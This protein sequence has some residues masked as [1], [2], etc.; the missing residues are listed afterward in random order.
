MRGIVRWDF[1]NIPQWRH[2][3]PVF[4]DDGQ[5]AK[6]NVPY[7]GWTNRYEIWGWV[8]CLLQKDDFH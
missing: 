6:Q 1:L 8:M 7:S 5:H 3:I 4:M 2:E